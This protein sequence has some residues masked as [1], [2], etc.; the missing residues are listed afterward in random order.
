MSA[1]E[2]QQ[3]PSAPHQPQV[4]VIEK[5]G[6]G[7]A[8]AGFVCGLLSALFGLIPILFFFSFPLSILGIV[9][10][11][12]GWRRARRDPSR[13]GKGLS[14]AGLVLGIIGFVLAIV[15]VAII[16]DAAEDLEEDLEEL[17]RELEQP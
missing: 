14:I 13:G 11:A 8:V 9:F 3:P 1:P 4:V 12:I 15:S 6:N 7:L 17:E 16:E 5:R 10:S 2:A